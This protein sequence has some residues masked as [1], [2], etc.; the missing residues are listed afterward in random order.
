MQILD[1]SEVTHSFDER[2]PMGETAVPLEEASGRLFR[3]RLGTRF[4][5]ASSFEKWLVVK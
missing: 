1:Q 5:T 2:T 3:L 4:A